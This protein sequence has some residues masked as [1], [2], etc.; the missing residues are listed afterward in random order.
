MWL[1]P[2]GVYLPSTN[3]ANFTMSVLNN[4]KELGGQQLCPMGLVG[5]PID[6]RTQ[7]VMVVTVLAVVPALKLDLLDF[8]GPVLGKYIYHSTF[9]CSSWA[10]GVKLLACKSIFRSYMDLE[11]SSWCW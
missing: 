5:R 2:T 8:G 11:T 1:F 10:P 3:L 4:H 9:T 6:C 7:M